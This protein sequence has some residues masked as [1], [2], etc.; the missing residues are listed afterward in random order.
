M[1]L[2]LKAAAIAFLFLAGLLSLPAA[3][4]AGIP[5]DATVRPDLPIAW[6]I[7]TGG[8]ACTKERAAVSE[9][10]DRILAAPTPETARELALSQTRL[11]H[12]A[13]S[14]ARWIMPFSGSIGKANRKL[15]DYEAR[16]RAAQS[17]EAVAQE[18]SGLVRL[19]SA[20]PGTVTDAV[21][22]KGKTCVY[23]TGEIV[24]IIIGFLF[25]IIPGIIFLFL[26]C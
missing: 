23:T 6:D 15:E 10:R 17:Q 9:Y 2:R 20:Q 5:K 16:V 12:K 18:F 19:A 26:L 13:L 1:T 3:V 25:A 14:R 24:I 22:L 7:A 21:E 8:C 11:A 4:S